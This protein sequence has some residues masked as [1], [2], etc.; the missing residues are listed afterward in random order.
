M[1]TTDGA[2]NPLVPYLATVMRCPRC[3]ASEFLPASERVVCGS[4][5]ATYLDPEGVLD[6]APGHQPR[7]SPPWRPQG[8]VVSWE[9]ETLPKRWAALGEM[10]RETLVAFATAWFR[11]QGQGP[12]LDV[13]TAHGWMARQLARWVG[14]A[15]VLGLDESLEVLRATQ[16]ST[17][18]PGMGWIRAAM[19]RLPFA[20]GAVAGMVQFGDPGPEA[21]SE[22]ALREFA[23]VLAPD[24]RLVG[25]A[26]VRGDGWTAVRDAFRGVFAQPVAPGD[27]ALRRRIQGAGFD[28]LA[29]G[30][31]G[32]LALIAARRRPSGAA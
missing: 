22:D 11:V 12:V 8:E 9:D 29:W 25:M 20:D 15:R 28:L 19:D 31:F 18:D 23:R 7:R 13:Q 1:R 10:D 24:G 5:G 2:W 16:A 27:E 21:W 6:M 3:G 14:V 4:C 17:R 26:R 32:E 30:R